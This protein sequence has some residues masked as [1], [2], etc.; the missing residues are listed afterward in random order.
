MENTLGCFIIVD[1]TLD[2][3]TG[4]TRF[5]N[6]DKIDNSIRVGNTFSPNEYLGTSVN[7]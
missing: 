2:K 1:K 3:F 6:H 4:S 7:L 5:Y